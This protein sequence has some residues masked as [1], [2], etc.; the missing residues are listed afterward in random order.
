MAGE[1]D[2][3]LHVSSEPITGDNKSASGMESDDVASSSSNVVIKKMA[4][5]TTPSM[6]DY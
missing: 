3:T 6:F 2:Q 4:A 1:T 5:K